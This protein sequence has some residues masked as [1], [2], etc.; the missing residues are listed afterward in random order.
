MLT[1]LLVNYQGDTLVLEVWSVG[2]DVRYVHIFFIFDLTV[3][4]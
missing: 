4:L 2:I 1:L 3:N